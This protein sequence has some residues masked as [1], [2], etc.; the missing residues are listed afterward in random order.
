MEVSDQ[1]HAPATPV[2][3][4]TELEAEWVPEQVWMHGKEKNSC[5]CWESNPN[6]LAWK[7]KEVYLQWIGF[8]ILTS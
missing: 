6:P 5:L 3:K 2:E 1:L 8:V 4:V 7:F